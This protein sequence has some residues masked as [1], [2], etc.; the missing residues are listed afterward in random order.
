MPYLA[1]AIVYG[2]IF[3]T[4]GAAALWTKGATAYRWRQLD[5]AGERGRWA[6]QCVGTAAAGCSGSRQS[7]KHAVP[8]L[9]RAAPLSRLPCASRS[10][11]AVSGAF[12][13]WPGIGLPVV[14]IAGLEDGCAGRL[15]RMERQ[16]TGAKS[17]VH[18]P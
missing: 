5:S 11:S 7:G 16:A 17:A 15:D 18:R 10:E 2:R 14:V 12:G 13:Q 9:D 3:G 8:C 1:S 4:A 6:G